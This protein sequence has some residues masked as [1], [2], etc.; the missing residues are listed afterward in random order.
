MR[1]NPKLFAVANEVV[2]ME[3]Q[4][5]DGRKIELYYM[6]DFDGVKEEFI[7]KG[8][9]AA[10][11]S[12]DGTNYRLFIEKGYYDAVGELYTQPVNKIWVEF[13]DKTDVISRKFSRFFMIPLM[14]VAIAVCIASWALKSVIGVAADYIAIGVLIVAFIVMLFV[15]SKTKKAI[16]K[17]NINSRDLIIK[18]IG[19]ARFDK[20]LEIQKEYMDE[21]YQKLYPEEEDVEEENED[22]IEETKEEV[23]LEENKEEVSKEDASD[24]IKE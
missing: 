21:Y 16:M 17:E 6:D 14:I 12:V 1:I 8:Q 4:E 2:P 10:W 13:W 18:H 20:L 19:E 23:A 5:F 3:T 11:S 15:N 9:F 7:N 22:N 24:E